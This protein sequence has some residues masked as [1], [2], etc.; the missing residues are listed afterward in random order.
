M[1]VITGNPGV[2]KHTVAAKLAQKLD[3]SII[4][5]N[6][7]AIESKVFEKNGST[8]DVNVKKLAKIVKKITTKN[9]LVVGHLAPYVLDKKQVNSVIVLRKNPY[10][11]V[12]I[13]KKRKYSQKKIIEN[14]KN[15]FADFWWN[16]LKKV[17][18]FIISSPCFRDR[19]KWIYSGIECLRG[20]V[21]R[22]KVFSH[23]SR[24]RDSVGIS[25]TSPDQS[26]I[27]LPQL[28]TNVVD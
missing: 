21:A 11:L 14:I 28:S 26:N 15:N 10:K 13:Y 4:D 22:L 20:L 27:Q 5:L 16:V 1:I 12:P 19:C 24:L 9:S 3:L 25:P 2:G 7:T 17:T 6:K 8:L 23:F 18:R